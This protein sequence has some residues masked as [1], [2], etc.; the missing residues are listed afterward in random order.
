MAADTL[1]DRLVGWQDVMPAP[2]GLAGVST[3][4]SVEGHSMVTGERRQRS[5]GEVGEGRRA[6]RMIHDGRHKLIYYPVGNRVQLFDLEQDPDEFIDLSGAGSHAEVRQH[7][8]GDLIEE[9]YGSDLEWLRDGALIGLP[10]EE[11][12]PTPNR[13]L[14]GQRGL[15]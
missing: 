6:T 1:D 5:Y 3:P 15:H 4:T 7:L 2:L 10:E 12:L 11:D 8:E 9:F 13:G 14:S